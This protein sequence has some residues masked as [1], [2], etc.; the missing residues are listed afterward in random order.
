MA[1]SW[2]AKR[3]IKKYITG[4]KEDRRGRDAADVVGSILVGVCSVLLAISFPLATV[5]AGVNIVFRIPDLYAFEVDRGE[6]LNEVKLEITAEQ[7]GDVISDYFRHKT[8]EFVLT[9]EL[10]GRTIQVFTFFEKARMEQFR[11]ILDKC[12]TLSVG[13]AGLTVVLFLLLFAFGRKRLLRGAFRGS[14]AVY[15][16][17][18]GFVVAFAG[19]DTLRTRILQVMDLT[20]SG[21][22]RLLQFFGAV[23]RF[24]A[25]GV[26]IGISLILYIA[27]FSV[28]RWLY[29]EEE[30]LF[31]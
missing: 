12:L 5:T 10:R 11:A 18:A 13:S 2:K 6:V 8:D 14:V 30:R 21:D 22:E 20:F 16:L 19:V 24:E 25:A 27:V 31:A 29:R 4:Y 7:V 26:V 3:Q 15:V 28:A 1:R 17:S 23:Y 9:S